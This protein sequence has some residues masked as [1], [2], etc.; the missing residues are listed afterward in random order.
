MGRKAN[1]GVARAKARA[2]GIM[3]AGWGRPGGV[4]AARWVI[5]VITVVNV[6][7]RETNVVAEIRF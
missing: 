7:R 5:F 6:C 3:V 4:L 2:V 1:V